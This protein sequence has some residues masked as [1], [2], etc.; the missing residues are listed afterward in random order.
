MIPIHLKL[1]EWSVFMFIGKNYVVEVYKERSFSKAAKNLY[2]SQP[3]LS[4]TIKRIEDKIGCQI[5]DRSTT[6]IKLTDCGEEYIKI[7]TQITMLEEN[8]DIYM[9]NLKELKIGKLIIGGSNLNISYV[10]PPIIQEFNKLYPQITIKIQEGNIEDLEK[11]LYLGEIDI[12]VDGCD[13]DP[14]KYTTYIYHPETIILAIPKN[15]KCNNFL[16]KYQLTQREIIMDKHL[17]PDFPCLPLDLVSNETFIFLKAES[18]TYKRVEKLCD[19]CNFHPKILFYL[20]QLSSAFRM[21]YS[22]LGISFISDT[23]IKN[24]PTHTSIYYYKISGIEVFRNIQFYK[25]KDK[26]LTYAM[27]AFLHITKCYIKDHS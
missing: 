5:F 10:L 1:Y 27:S 21:V 12:L 15:F 26:R 19:R 14:T 3:S 4:A 11:S 18:D 7:A 23:M 22:G 2:I 13:M 9:E 17:N 25:K 20:D 24:S 16:T 6:P 8:F